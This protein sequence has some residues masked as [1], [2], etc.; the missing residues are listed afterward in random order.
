MGQ[1]GQNW[2]LHQ[3]QVGLKSIKSVP[4]PN[5]EKLV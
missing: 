5:L 4:S 3:N 1:G 2:S